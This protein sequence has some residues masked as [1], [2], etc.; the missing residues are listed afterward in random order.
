F[1]RRMDYFLMDL[2]MEPVKVEALLDAL[3]EHHLSTLE[4]VCHA[5]GDIVDMVKFGDDLGMTNGP[6]M[7]PETYQKFFKPRHKQLCD[8][9]KKNSSMHTYLHSCGS[10]YKLIPDL[11]EAGFEILNPV[12]TNCRDMEPEK[13][14]KEFGK[15]VTFWGGGIDTA[16]VLNH[17]KPE[18]IRRHVLDRLEIFNQGGGYVFNT[19]HNILPDVPPENIVAMFDAVQE[20][21]S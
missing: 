3:M 1:L 15:E 4:N 19:V 14:K 16:S 2:V 5:V 10:I 17:G 11:I 6:F 20:F 8:F 9:A 21:N 13:L 7:S 18:E 12:Q